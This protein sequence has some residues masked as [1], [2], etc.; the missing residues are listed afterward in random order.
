MGAARDG[1]M[2][3]DG[4]TPFTPPQQ[5]E[6]RVEELQERLRTLIERLDG[7]AVRL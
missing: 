4:R 2:T 5:R 6:T 3:T 7:I 1:M